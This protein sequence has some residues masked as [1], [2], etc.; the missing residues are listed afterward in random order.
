MTIASDEKR[1]NEVATFRFG[2]IAEFVTGVL[3]TRGEK[4]KLLR[5][6]A[7]RRYTIPG[8]HRTRVARETLLKWIRDYEQGG[9]ELSALGP[10]TRADKGCYRMLEP[11]IRLSIKEILRESPSANVPALIRELRHR[12]VLSD[13]VSINRATLYRY[14]NAE[15]LRV[16]NDDANDRRRFETDH[17]NELWQSDVM[18]G[19]YVLVEGRK[20]KAYL[21]AFLDDHS[22]FI[23]HARFSLNETFD[24][25]REGLKCAIEKHGLP[26]KLYVDNGS[27]YRSVQLEHALALLGVALSHSR[28]YTPQGRGKIERW[29]RRVRD[30]F[31]AI[32]LPTETT[33]LQLNA[34]FE[35][36][37]DEYQRTEHQTTGQPPRDRYFASLKC[38]RPAPARLSEYFRT[39]ERRQVKRDRTFRLRGRMFE[40]PVALIDR[41]IELRFHEERPDQVEMYFEGMGFGMATLLDPSLNAKLGRNWMTKESA[42]S[43]ANSAE[44]ARDKLVTSQ[45][46]AEPELR[47]GSLP[48]GTGTRPAA[49]A[50]GEVGCE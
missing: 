6:K 27:C 25:F 48:L 24:T 39:V 31:L 26:Q 2:L 28:P 15:K 42:Q 20:R 14:L 43:R 22:R 29:F 1:K 32:K 16:V 37:L 12:K 41:S 23:L 11:A 9:K 3:F 7:S 45:A 10:K 50:D 47:S 30:E 46:V 21:L 8:S 5:E 35:Q 38:T 4:E 19:P 34:R 40:A 13:A 44:A 49:S 17:P 33:L 18:H 36:W